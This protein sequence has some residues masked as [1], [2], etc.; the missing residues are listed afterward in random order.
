MGK[1]VGVGPLR[2]VRHEIFKID[3]M[4]QP[5]VDT[6]RLNDSVRC[7]AEGPEVGHDRPELN[8]I[9]AAREDAYVTV[10]EI[11][12]LL[13]IT[14]QPGAGPF[15]PV[16]HLRGRCRIGDKPFGGDARQLH[17]FLGAP[18]PHRTGAPRPGAA[19]SEALFQSDDTLTLPCLPAGRKMIRTMQV[20]LPP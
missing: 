14:H 17:V 6:E 3:K 12:L 4:Q 10:Q 11:V 20:F 2:L 7:V 1:I 5:G 19:R 18:A 13:G 9:G 15:D 16:S 8:A